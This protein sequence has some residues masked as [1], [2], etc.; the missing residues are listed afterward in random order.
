M[1]QCVAGTNYFIKVI[2][3]YLFIK[4]WLIFNQHNEFNLTSAVH[5]LGLQINAHVASYLLDMQPN[6]CMLTC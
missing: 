5:S 1:K 2:L 4:S 6:N 3:L